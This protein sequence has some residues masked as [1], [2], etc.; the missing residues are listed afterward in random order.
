MKVKVVHVI[1]TLDLGGA[2]V[3]AV[4]IAKEA[5]MKGVSYSILPITI[6]DE[7][8]VS[9]FK[10]VCN[11]IEPKKF[12]GSFYL[13]AAF[14]ILRLKPSHLVVSLWKSIIPVLITRFVKKHK[15]SFFVHSSVFFSLFD[16]FFSS[17]AMKLSDN[18]L[19]DSKSSLRF[20]NLLG[21]ERKA[22][23]FPL[24]LRKI[25]YQT[26]ESNN[27]LYIGRIAPIKDLLTA[28]KLFSKIY[29]IDNTLEF[30]IYGPISDKLYADEIKNFICQI[31]L[32]NNIIFKGEVDNSEIPN[33]L[34]GYQY[35]LCTSKAEGMAITV[36]EAMQ[37]GTIPIVTNVGEI[38]YYCKDRHNSFIIAN[39]EK[40]RELLE[41]IK[42]SLFVK[43]LKT[44]ISLNASNAFSEYQ[45][46]TESIDSFVNLISK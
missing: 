13:G 21:Y 7:V 27:F 45:T 24:M 38:R 20:L 26:K 8:L 43:D 11:I 25:K 3:A 9:K 40:E 36:T 12:L 34:V 5:K 46:L 39:P 6:K 2:E 28:I 30:H 10:N 22:I 18:I 44:E 1:P 32:R 14:N 16:R 23:Y 35:F 17:V 42:E 31:G 41:G 15:F 29:E 4:N 37:S 19:A 33:I